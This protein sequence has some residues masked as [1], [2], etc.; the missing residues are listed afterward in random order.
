MDSQF[1]RERGVTPARAHAELPLP[2]T[3]LPR[4]NTNPRPF[5]IDVEVRQF[6]KTSTPARRLV[7]TNGTEDN[8]I[9]VT[10]GE[11]NGITPTMGGVALD[12]DPVP[13]LVIGGDRWVYI[14]DVCVFGGTDSHTFTIETESSS[15]PPTPSLGPTGFTSYFLIGAVELISGVAT[16]VQNRE[17]GDLQVDSFGSVNL[18]WQV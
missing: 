9:Q 8:K 2:A 3:P 6:V 1:D 5:D 11:V 10:V 15:T 16:I 17:G 12:N 4:P 14:K 13:E 7:L 18:W